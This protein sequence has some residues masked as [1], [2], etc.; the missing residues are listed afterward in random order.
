M[1][2]FSSSNK[3]HDGFNVVLEILDSSIIFHLLLVDNSQYTQFSKVSLSHHILPGDGLSQGELK[4]F[5]SIIE[6]GLFK[7][8][9]E[10]NKKLGKKMKI[11]VKKVTAVLFDPWFSLEN[12]DDIQVG[13]PGEESQVGEKLLEEAIKKLEPEG[14]PKNNPLSSY[15][16]NKS[17]VETFIHSVKINGY[18]IGNPLGKKAKDIRISASTYTASAALLEVL[19][20]EMELI[21]GEQLIITFPKCCSIYSNISNLLGPIV[22]IDIEENNTPIVFISGDSPFVSPTKVIDIGINQLINAVIKS[23]GSTRDIALSY[24][25]LSGEDALSDD[26]SIVVKGAIGQTL[27]DWSSKVLS[28]IAEWSPYHSKKV[29]IS[30]QEKF[31][32]LFLS[33]L[34]EDALKNDVEKV[35]LDA[36]SF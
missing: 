21:H 36:C 31:L 3:N 4:I 1:S 22:F 34:K 12:H 10:A 24:I 18:T 32:P 35:V 27:S 20:K 8:A 33:S 17:M 29:I 15:A 26:V 7:L 14:L 23:T 30:R 11:K 25:R 6:K 19:K 13:K 16:R 9:E 2:L 5:Q 28:S